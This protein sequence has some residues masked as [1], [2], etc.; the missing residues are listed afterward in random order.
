MRAPVLGTPAGVGAFQR[1]LAAQQA[2]RID[3]AIAAYRKAIRVNPGLA[4]AQF[5]LGQLLR[6]RGDYEQAAHC[7]DGAARLRPTAADAWLN[8]GA[9]LE[10][11]ERFS[12]AGRAYAQAIECGPDDPVGYYNQGNVQLALGDFGS[13]VESYRQAIEKGPDHAD[14][15]WNLATAL[16]MT[17]DFAGGWPQYDWRWRKDGL[18]PA[19]RF[20]IPL[21]QG[22]PVADRRILVWREQGLGDE[23]LFATCLRELVAAGADVTLAASPRLVT[24]FQRAFPSVTVIEDGKWKGLSFDLHCPIGSL[25]RYLRASR[26]SF[27]QDGKFLV[28][29]SIQA[30]RWNTRLDALG[31]GLNVGI[32]WRSGLRTEERVRHYSPLDAWGPVFA[33]PGIHWINLQYDECEAELK[34]AEAAFGI[35]IHR[36]PKEDLKQDLESV[37]GLLWNLDWVVTAPTAVSSLAGAAGVRTLQVDVGSDWTAHGEECSPWFPSIRLVRRPFGTTDW[38]RVFGP[39]AARLDQA[40][41]QSAAIA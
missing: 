15:Q 8:L 25:P 16:L 12:D 10:R 24:L 20:P 6:Q 31:P 34:A 14:A 21:W 1:G 23:I 40:R 18:D 33:V 9:M 27:P 32:C 19:N 30:T 17:G 5:N 41:E 3:D 2:G 28:P 11:L 22:E 38:S 4:P 37:A 36:W 13:A 29:N 7:F 35:T 26:R 39:I